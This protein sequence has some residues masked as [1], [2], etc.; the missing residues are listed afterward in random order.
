MGG[1]RTKPSNAELIKMVDKFMKKIFS[2]DNNEESTWLGLAIIFKSF[3]PS[4]S[5]I[6]YA[7]QFEFKNALQ[8]PENVDAKMGECRS[9]IC[10]SLMA[11]YNWNRTLAVEALTLWLTQR[12]QKIPEDIKKMRTD[13]WKDFGKKKLLNS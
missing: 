8:I 1:K 11:K 5:E 10:Y 13:F 12:N 7:R 6:S 4:K 9:K 2:D 3:Y